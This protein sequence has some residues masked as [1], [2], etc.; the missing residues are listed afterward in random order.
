[1]E[2]KNAVTGFILAFFI[3]LFL[4]YFLASS[5]I[6]FIAPFPLLTFLFQVA[7][8]LLAL[9]VFYYYA[10][11]KYWITDSRTIMLSSIGFLLMGIS[12]IPYGLKYLGLFSYDVNAAG[13]YY[14]L[15]TLIASI[16]ITSCVFFKDGV[17]KRAKE[18]MLAT[19]VVLSIAYL[20]LLTA[21]IMFFSSMLPPVFGPNEETLP[22][23]VY[24]SHAIIIFLAFTSIYFARVFTESK[25]EVMFWFSVGIALLIMAEITWTSFKLQADDVFTWLGR[26]YRLAAFAAL[27]IGMKQVYI[28]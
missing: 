2:F 27:L 5:S 23:R 12:T 8:L 13:H 1:M 22:F 3:P 7:S 19:F 28:E 4:N 10:V 25:N 16:L 6:Y 24:L 26:I 15:T 14:L 18:R 21:V 11:E 9:G 20:I 17:S